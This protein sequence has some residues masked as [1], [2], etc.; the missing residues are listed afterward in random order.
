MAFHIPDTGKSFLLLSM[1]FLLLL[2]N[3]Y[4]FVKTQ[5]KISS[6]EALSE[7][8][9][10]NHPHPNVP[11]A[12]CTDYCCSHWVMILL[13][14][15]HKRHTQ[16]SKRRNRGAFMSVSHFSKSTY[17]KYKLHKYISNEQMNI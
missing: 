14:I 13:L 1:P 11:G 8:G 2:Y 16:S 5:G 10:V 15:S 9:H 4:L 12:L 17:T 6:S 3:S 7:L